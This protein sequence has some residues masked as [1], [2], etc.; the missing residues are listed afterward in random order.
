MNVNSVPDIAE[1]GIDIRTIPSQQHSQVKDGL[2]SYLGEEVEIDTLVN[3]GAIWTNPLDTWIKEVF[4]IMTSILGEE[5]EIRT[6]S[7]F[8]DAAA[9]TPAYG[10]V[11]TVILGPGEPLMAHQTDEYC[12]IDRIDEA[13]E[14]YLKLA[15]S[16][17]EL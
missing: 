7:Y 16:W 13:V 5:I 1:V 9:L 8:T 14:A 10:G 17:C 12:Q 3:V 2:Q 6:A 15:Q 11:P 4:K